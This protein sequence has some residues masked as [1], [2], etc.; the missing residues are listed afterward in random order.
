MGNHRYQ[1]NS[2]LAFLPSNRPC[3]CRLHHQSQY[4]PQTGERVYH[5]PGQEYYWDTRINLLKGERW[6]CS[7]E[8]ARKAGWRKSRV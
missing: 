2:W 6:F 3:R 8:A 7:E 4:K 1:D 5:D